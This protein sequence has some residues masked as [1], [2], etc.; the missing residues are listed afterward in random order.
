VILAA[1]AGGGSN[2][3]S[4]A[5]TIDGRFGIGLSDACSVSSSPIA[6]TSMLCIGA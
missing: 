4:K 3:S 1:C 5:E 2:V 6:K